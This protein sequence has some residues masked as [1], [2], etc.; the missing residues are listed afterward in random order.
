MDSS[1]SSASC[2]EE[3]TVTVP[4]IG[5]PPEPRSDIRDTRSPRTQ[6]RGRPASSSTTA[7]SS[8]VPR[9]RAAKSVGL[10]EALAVV[11]P[12]SSTSPTRRRVRVFS[13]AS[14]PMNPLTVSSAGLVR[15]ASG[16]SNCST[17][18][19]G[20]STAIRSPSLTASEKSWVTKTMVLRSSSCSRTS[21]SCSDARV[22]GST[23]PNGSSMSSTGGSAASARATPTRCC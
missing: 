15:I 3:S 1:P 14:S 20:P 5:N 11:A 16:V 12:C 18:D 8:L 6:R 2:S 4:V 10:S 23:A 9:N 7:H 21:S 17:D 22:M 19:P 13:A